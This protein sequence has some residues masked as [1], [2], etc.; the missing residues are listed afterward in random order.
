MQLTRSRKLKGVRSSLSLPRP[1][2]RTKL[3]L[4][5]PVLCFG[6][7]AAPS[8]FV[9]GYW[10]GHRSKGD[11]LGSLQGVGSCDWRNRSQDGDSVREFRV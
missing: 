8:S 5:R 9:L 11:V 10:K 7:T 2:A 1:H 6:F 3:T 4:L